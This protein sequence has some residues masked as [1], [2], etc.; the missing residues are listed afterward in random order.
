V[1]LLSLLKSLAPGFL[2]LFGYIA[3]DLIFGE[4]IGLFIGIGIGVLEFA[5]SFAKEKKADLFVAADTILLS[6]MGVMSLLLRNQIFFRLKPAIMEGMVA[7]A[8]VVLL[9]LPQDLLKSYMGHQVK[10]L[11]LGDGAMPLLRRSLTIMTVVFVLHVGLTVWS[12]LAAST[13]LWGFVSGGLLYLLLGAVLLVQWIAARKARKQASLVSGYPSLAWCLFV[14]DGTGKLFAAKT[15]R[16]GENNTS[17]DSPIRGSA[18]KALADMEARIG[19][20]LA[21]LGLDF[22][23][24]AAAR[25]TLA[26]RIAFILAAD[27]SV[28]SLPGAPDLPPVQSVLESGEEGLEVV[29]AVAIP[30]SAFPKGIDPT[31]RRFWSLSDLA[32]L[33]GTGK[34]AP[35]FERELKALLTLRMSL[36]GDAAASIVTTTNDAI[37]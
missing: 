11:A 29:F 1:N 15:A 5:V 28:R 24:I 3:A 8:M 31:E 21:G 35:A 14:F 25:Q 6:A 22:A 12:A 18:G 9:L 27:G 13:A 33:T 4:T 37:V 20:S 26:I 17:W 32:A 34:L 36:R 16:P 2:P 19:K 10:G 7:I 23:S 30:P